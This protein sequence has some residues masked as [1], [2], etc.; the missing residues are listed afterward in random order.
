MSARRTIRCVS[1]RSPLALAWLGLLCVPLA[2]ALAQ[3]PDDVRAKLESSKQ[4]LQ[5]T[6][7]RKQEI[8][9][10]VRAIADTYDRLRQQSVEKAQA[11]KDSEAKL[12]EIETR[13]AELREQENLVRGSLV[14]NHGS[15]AALLAALQRMG[16]NPP[17]VMVTRREDALAMVRSAMLLSATFPELRE[18]ALALSSRMA[19][20]ARILGDTKAEGEKYQSEV[21]RYRDDQM[22]LASLMEQQKKALAERQTQLQQIARTVAERTRDV[23]DVSDLIEKIE[24]TI[25]EQT[26]MGA[27]EKQLAQQQQSPAPAAPPAGAAQQPSVPGDQAGG[28]KVADA[29]GPSAGAASA[30]PLP[31][32][33]TEPGAAA[34]ARPPPELRPS[35]TLA[36]GDR[37]AMVSPGRI[38]PALP[39]QQTRGQL[40]LPAQGRTL[41][42]FGDRTQTGP[43]QGIVIETRHGAQV[44]SPSDAWVLYAGEFRSYGKILILN[45]G[46]G[47]HILLAGLNLIDVQ[48]GQFVLTGEPVGTMAPLPRG[49]KVDAANK[50]PVLYIEFRKDQKPIDPDPWWVQARKVQG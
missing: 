41:L 46:G 28:P 50:P 9:A 14:R 34:P 30:G 31:R 18:Q 6:Q 45:G 25:A 27:Y 7:R 42:K 49:A 43:S 37:L 5:E 22:Q 47:Y 38:Q 8:Q 44:T 33:T 36:P 11:I 23:A 10:D 35:I 15:I 26:R 40:P 17:P 3:S 21:A 29:T 19:E 2:G 48:V 39:F 32:A 20:L 13:L 16:R 24:K 1:S 4:A 12:T